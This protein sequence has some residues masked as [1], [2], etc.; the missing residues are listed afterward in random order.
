[1]RASKAQRE[2][3]A[4][5]RA[6]PLRIL[7]VDDNVDGVEML[8]EI[9]RITGY[10]VDV[11]HDGATGLGRFRS[12]RPDVAILD[13]GLP[14]LDGFSLAEQVRADVWLSATPLIAFSAYD[15]DHHR[16][17][18]H[19]AGFDH[20]LSKPADLERLHHLLREYDE[21]LA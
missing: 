17:R 15:A 16:V 6:K 8:A 4:A 10:D 14:V 20:H 19:Y 7:L 18:S 5:H 21:Q 3:V 13:L 2:R 11:A 9:L 12:F 1:M